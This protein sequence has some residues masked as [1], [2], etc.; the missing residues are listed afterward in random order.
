MGWL[1]CKGDQTPHVV[2]DPGQ[3]EELVT[4]PPKASKCGD[5]AVVTPYAKIQLA[6][7]KR[8]EMHEKVEKKNQKK[9]DETSQW[10][11]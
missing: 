7:A 2:L 11:C 1:D 5:V 4:P 8:A 6:A 3:D 9:K 10:L